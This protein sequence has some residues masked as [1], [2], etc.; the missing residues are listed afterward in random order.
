MTP[1]FRDR[2]GDNNFPL[3]LRPLK[4]QSL[5]HRR[6]HRVQ[7]NHQKPR[8][9]TGSQRRLHQGVQFLNVIP[10][11]QENQNRLI[12]RRRLHNVPNQKHNQIEINH[13][14][15][16]VLH[17]LQ[18]SLGEFTLHSDHKSLPFRVVMVLLLP[19]ADL[20]VVEGVIGQGENVLQKQLLNGIR[21]T[22]NQSINQSIT[23]L[24]TNQSITNQSTN[25]SITN[26]SINH[27]S[28]N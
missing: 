18:G 23:N 8:I 17:R 27:Q 25:Q 10:A 5:I 16:E 24:S 2:R 28:I 20:L 21:E 11:G 9:P 14:L 4:H 12:L 22:W 26:Q 6:H 13:R 3:V 19:P 1:C 15:V 7:R